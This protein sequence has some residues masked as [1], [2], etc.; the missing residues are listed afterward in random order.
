MS[1]F[2]GKVNVAYLNKAAQIFEPIKKTS[3]DKIR[4][5][6]SDY[7]LDIGCGP[8]IDVIAMASI[9]GSG[10]LAVGVDH[11]PDML[12]QAVKQANTA[13]NN[14]SIYFQQCDAQYLPF[15]NDSFDCCRSE[16]LFMHLENPLQVLTEVRRVTKSGGKIVIIDT[17][18]ASLSIDCGLPAIEQ[19]FLNYRI[20][21]IFSNGYAARNLYSMFRKLNF[22]NV[23]TEVFPLFTHD[24]NLFY[25]LSAQEVV[26]KQALADKIVNKA[27]LTIW[28]DQL[29]QAA[30]D[31][32]FYCSVNIVMV[33]GEK[34]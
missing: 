11:D 25:F 33:L 6:P 22:I 26:E 29:K 2:T 32:S 20:N 28:R 10:G 7:V 34:P 19:L 13:G 31:N 27:E 23:E 21:N 8:G 4:L 24:L 3:Y 30:A 15:A 16:R 1:Q 9:I 18:W 17:D 12:A 14:S 5:G